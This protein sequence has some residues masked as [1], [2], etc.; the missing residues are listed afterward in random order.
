MTHQ[1]HPLPYP[2]SLFLRDSWL[3]PRLST[4]PGYRTS[5]QQT[6]IPRFAKNSKGCL[7]RG[8]GW[9]TGCSLRF[10]CCPRLRAAEG[11][12]PLCQGC[13]WLHPW[14]P[15]APLAKPVTL[16]QPGQVHS[17]GQTDPVPVPAVAPRAQHG[18]RSQLWTKGSEMAFSAHASVSKDSGHRLCFSA[19]PPLLRASTPPCTALRSP[20]VANYL[21]MGKPSSLCGQAGPA[22]AALT[23]TSLATAACP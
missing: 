2:G 19:V 15:L 5:Q 18:A 17:C 9:L 3:F 8:A 21:L 7:R 13:C 16:L 11:P 12:Q 6:H 20:L 1:G 14:A 22:R 4:G 23:Q 10:W